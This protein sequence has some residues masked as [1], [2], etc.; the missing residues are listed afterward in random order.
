MWKKLPKIPFWNIVSSYN[1][2][3]S[4]R[5]ICGLENS[6]K[7]PFWNI[8]SSY[9]SKDTICNG[10][11]D[12]IMKQ[13]KLALSAVMI[14]AVGLIGT[15]FVTGLDMT[16]QE[17]FDALSSSNNVYGHITLV[18]SDPDGNILNYIQTDNVVG[19][20][21]KACLSELVFGDHASLCDATADSN[22]E[23]TTIALF[24]GETFT[25]TVNATLLNNILGS[26]NIVNVPG[27][28]L[29][30]GG[31]GVTVAVATS[32]DPVSGGQGSKTD[33][34]KTF[35]AGVNVAGQVV[36]GAALLNNGTGN[37]PGENPTAVLAAQVFTQGSVT[38]NESDTLLIT[39]TITL[40]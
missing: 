9:N 3:Y 35:T 38:L 30:N 32:G 17:K 8:I 4:I 28:T 10:I 7:D 21:G 19:I 1:S 26:G 22:T 6:L 27:L 24:N 25:D 29:R 13:E 39:W 18:H 36:D 5:G 2:K 37:T 14:V 31:Q 23:F 16:E 20:F 11:I 15:N 33:I 40:G 34:S 12:Q